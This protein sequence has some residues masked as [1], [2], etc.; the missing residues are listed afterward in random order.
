MSDQLGTDDLTDKGLEIGGDSVHTVLE[1]ISELFA[2]VNEVSDTLSPLADLELVTLGHVHTHGNL[3]SF[4]DLVCLLLVLGDLKENFSLII[5]HVVTASV[6]S[7]HQLGVD[8]II[9]DD[10]GHFGEVPS[11]PLLQAHAEGVDVLVHLVDECDSLNNWLVLAVDILSAAVAR[12]G[13]TKTEL[14]SLDIR[15]IDFYKMEC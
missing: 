10:L 14:G 13:V 3:G 11:E 1:V 8:G 6:E 15:F 4:N 2:E 12:V 5:G 7:V 9:I